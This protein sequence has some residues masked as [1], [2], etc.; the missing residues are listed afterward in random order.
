MATVTETLIASERNKLNA[1]VSEAEETVSL[2]NLT[3]RRRVNTTLQDILNGEL[4]AFSRLLEQLAAQLVQDAL[5]GAVGGVSG[6]NEAR[7][8]AV[9]RLQNA[10]DLLAVLEQSKR[11][12]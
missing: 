5:V 4:K 12:L 11:N 10:A 8:L 9:S 2:L 7:R 3:L 1:F 6:A